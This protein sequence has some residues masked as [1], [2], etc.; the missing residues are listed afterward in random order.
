MINVQT[1]DF[2]LQ[3]EYDKLRANTSVGAVVTFS[4]LVRDLNQG[5]TVTSLTLEHYPGMTEKSMT[6]I[7]EQAKYRWNIIDSTVIHRVGTLKL[8]DQIVF[9]GVA[10]LHRQDAFAA[11]EFIMDHLKSAAPF[12]KKECTADNNSRWLDAQQADLDAI[13]KWSKE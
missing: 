12:W 9:V 6:Q 2:S 5:Q 7:V 4:G 10:C 8:S 1:E 3:A 13:R 11:C